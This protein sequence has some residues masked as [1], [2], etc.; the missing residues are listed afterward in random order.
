MQRASVRTH[1]YQHLLRRLRLSA[2]Y[3]LLAH[4]RF[5]HLI[6]FTPKRSLKL[7]IGVLL[8]LILIFGNTRGFMAVKIH[9]LTPLSDDNYFVIICSHIGAYVISPRG[10][11]MC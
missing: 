8:S 6:L 7:V 3:L 5:H 11:V 2:L 10:F 9:T 1:E 4:A